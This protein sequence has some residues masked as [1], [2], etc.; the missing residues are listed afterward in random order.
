MTQRTQRSLLKT[1][2]MKWQRLETPV[3]TERQMGKFC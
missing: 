3:S 1:K 2:A